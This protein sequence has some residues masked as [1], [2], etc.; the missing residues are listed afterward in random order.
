M[1][2]DPSDDKL[3]N[4]LAQFDT[5]KTSLSKPVKKSPSANSLTDLE[6]EFNYFNLNCQWNY[7]IRYCRWQYCTEWVGQFLGE[8]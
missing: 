2:E 4:F 3:D 7:L 1:D 8:N 5:W 6:G